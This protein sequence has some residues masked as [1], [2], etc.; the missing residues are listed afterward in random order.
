[1][2]VILNSIT[3]RVIA[4]IFVFVG[5]FWATLRIIDYWDIASKQSTVTGQF[6]TGAPTQKSTHEG[7]I[8]ISEKSRGAETPFQKKAGERPTTAPLFGEADAQLS[9]L[10]VTPNV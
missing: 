6:P 7:Q 8:A 3:V 2:V 1:M 9:E 4:G 10:T 5:S